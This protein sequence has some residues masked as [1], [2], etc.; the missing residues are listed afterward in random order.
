M[1][2]HFID[3]FRR[4]QISC[5]A[6]QGCTEAEYG[7]RLV[8]AREKDGYSRRSCRELENTEV[9]G[10]HT[11]DGRLKRSQVPFL[12]LP[13]LKEGNI[14]PEDDWKRDL[15]Q[16][17]LVFGSSREKVEIYRP[18]VKQIGKPERGQDEAEE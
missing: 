1:V 9:N 5:V 17:R 14:Q 4:A 18:K 7:R 3:R 12:E 11:L 2:S 6:V 13:R 16:A 10:E 8:S 15:P